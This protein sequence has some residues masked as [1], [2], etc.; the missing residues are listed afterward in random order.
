M[1]KG[2]R[3][4]CTLL[5]M[6]VVAVW[7]EAMSCLDEMANMQ[8]GLYAQARKALTWTANIYGL[9]NKFESRYEYTTFG[10]TT[11]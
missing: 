2:I 4:K 5:K 1:D 8:R 7:N 11:L 6:R 10:K 9:Q 3:W